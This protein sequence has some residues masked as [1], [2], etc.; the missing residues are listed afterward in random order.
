MTTRKSLYLLAIPA[1]AIAL[2]VYLLLLAET[3]RPITIAY[4]NVP[5]ASLSNTYSVM[6]NDVN[7]PVELY[8]TATGNVA[9]A[10]F[11][12]SSRADVVVTV[13][14]AI[15]HYV[16]SPT[17]YHLKTTVVGNKLSFTLS[18]PQRLVLRKVNH[19]PEELFL[20]AYA[21]EVNAPH[22]GDSNVTDALSQPGIETANTND[23][24]PGINNA[25]SA[26]SASGG[27]I[28]YFPPGVYTIRS[29]INLKS[30]VTIYLAAAAVLQVAADYTCCFHDQGVINFV[31]LIDS[32]LTGRGI[33]NGNA[34]HIPRANLDFHML[35][36]EN[37][38]HLEIDDV[39]LLDQGVTGIR[40]VDCHNSS[41]HNVEIIANNPNTESDGIDFDSSSDI[42]VD[43]AFIYSSDDNTSQGGGSGVRH[44]IK[45]IYN[46]TVENSV[47][48]N[49]RTG[50]TIKIG[51]GDPQTSIRNETFTNLNIVSAIQIAAFYPTQGA[52]IESIKLSNINA[53][54]VADRIWEFQIEVPNW[55]KWNGHLGH[56]HD[57][58]I[59]NVSVG[60]FGRRSSIF[61]GYDASRDV[62]RIAFGNYSVAGQSMTNLT[63]A[64]IDTDRF[65][66][67]I[68]FRQ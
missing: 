25:I 2:A 17:T 60:N 47:L 1:I 39:L 49:A 57:I 29:S 6:V 27:G 28:L 48:F 15:T 3:P 16:L 59:D 7:V 12:F 68:S 41:V 23:N 44:T 62:A 21:P 13:G 52:N 37:A 54:Y 22:L 45:D 51:T 43:N 38:S 4:D 31:D 34:V 55:E 14:E 32:R 19:L 8:P 67:D 24:A 58:A 35:Y 46:I 65:V 64:R 53:D 30:H 9:F 36:T 5:S 61:L 33:V 26:I 40:L 66:H 56:I 50:D 63:T 42:L 20:L 10:R 18:R 11:S